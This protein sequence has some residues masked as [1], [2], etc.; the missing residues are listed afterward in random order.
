MPQYF[1]A[2]T[3]PLLTV[4]ISCL[5][6][7]MIKSNSICII[8]AS[9]LA[10]LLRLRPTVACPVCCVVKASS[11]ENTKNQQFSFLKKYFFILEKIACFGCFYNLCDGFGELWEAGWTDM[12]ERT[13]KMC[14]ALQTDE[15][16]V[17]MFLSKMFHL[18]QQWYWRVMNQILSWVT[19]I[20]ALTFATSQHRCC[21]L[22][23]KRCL[24]L[25]SVGWTGPHTSTAPKAGISLNN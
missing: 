24:P 2:W 23:W 6:Q 25:L 19:G 21:W 12:M 16:K 22:L 14:I 1:S 9:M 17:K 10:H 15:Q 3:Q 13:C 8:Q 11:F 20:A 5:L 4:I 7:T 18:K